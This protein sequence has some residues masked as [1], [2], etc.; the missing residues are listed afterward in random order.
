[1][2]EPGSCEL[3]GVDR[4]RVVRAC[5]AFSSGLFV[6]CKPSLV[7]NHVGKDDSPP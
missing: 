5:G 1:M 3:P 6:A 2:S 4:R 7:R